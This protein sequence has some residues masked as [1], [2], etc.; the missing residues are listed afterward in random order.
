METL[1]PAQ[2][3]FIFNF[4]RKVNEING[5][6]P[7]SFRW[8]EKEKSTN[9]VFWPAAFSEPKNFFVWVSFD[10][11]NVSKQKVSYAKYKVIVQF[12]EK[13][14]YWSKKIFHVDSKKQDMEYIIRSIVFWASGENLWKAKF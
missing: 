11:F 9:L 5:P 4:R 14:Q 2:E 8:K 6:T 10:Y 12:Y 7:I 1:T 3:M 13:D